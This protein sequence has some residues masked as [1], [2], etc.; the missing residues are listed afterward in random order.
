V[1]PPAVGKSQATAY[2]AA[3]IDKLYDVVRSPETVLAI[4][5]LAATGMRRGE[6]LGLAFDAID[7][8]NATITIRRTVIEARVD[9]VRT[10]IIRPI[11]K[12][13]ASLRTF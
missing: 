6:L 8:A 3:D 9:G 7:M 10:R 11:A 1:K 5:L 2:A 13:K 4:A 12:T